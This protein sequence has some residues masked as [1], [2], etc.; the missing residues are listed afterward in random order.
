MGQ[1]RATRKEFP[2]ALAHLRKSIELRRPKALE[3]RVA[4]AATLVRSGKPDEA[5]SVALALQK[6]FP[7]S[8]AGVVLEGDVAMAVRKYPDAIAAYRKASSLEKS[9]PL[10]IKLNEA[11]SANGQSAEADN[12]VRA[13]IKERP[14][15]LLLRTYV[16]QYFVNRGR[17]PDAIENYKAVLAKQPDNV[18]A[19]NNLAWALHQAKEPNALETAEKAYSLAPKSPAVLDRWA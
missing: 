1:L 10:Q 2:A 14:D 13:M 8:A 4:L 16:S 9:V 12:A 6:D 7:K 18:S 3:P 15:D 5:K 19:L 11:M 17:W